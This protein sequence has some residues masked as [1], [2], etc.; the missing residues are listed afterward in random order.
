MAILLALISALSYGTSDFLAG[1]A[2]R[3]WAAEPVAGLAV[4]VG[5]LGAAAGVVLFDG[6]G[7]S[8]HAL[9]WGAVSGLGTGIGSLCLYRGFAAASMTVVATL[10]GVLA[11][12]V[13]VV[14]GLALGNHLSVHR[15]P[16][17]S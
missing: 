12:I 10:S 15:L 17:A 13:P 9:E 2:S 4:A 11:A 6:H 5:V 1:V 14:V 8:P 16:P 3:R 7:P